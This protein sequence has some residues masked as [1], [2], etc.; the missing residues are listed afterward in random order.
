MDYNGVQGAT[1]SLAL[2]VDAD[3]NEI[4]LNPNISTEIKVIL[5]FIETKNI[6]LKNLLLSG[7]TPNF[8]SLQD[9]ILDSANYHVLLAKSLTQTK[10]E[11]TSHS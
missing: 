7:A 2:K 10:D 4:F 5:V 1:D 11:K 9:T 8:E 3:L 6:R